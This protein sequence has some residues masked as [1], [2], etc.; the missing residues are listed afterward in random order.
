MAKKKNKY[1]GHAKDTMGVGVVSMAGLGAM[2]A[3][4][5]IPGMPAA[6]GTV[7]GIAGSGLALANVGQL[8]KVGMDI[9]PGTEK[10]KKKTGNK[11]IDNILG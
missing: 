9:M 5:S 4:G 10:K 11:T 3:I 7:T 1:V 2:G 8:A 6:A